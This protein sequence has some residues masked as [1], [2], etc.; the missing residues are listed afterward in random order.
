MNFKTFLLSMLVFATAVARTA[1]D[2]VLR[3]QALPYVNEAGRDQQ[4]GNSKQEC[5]ACRHSEISL[6][7]TAKELFRNF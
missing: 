1:D 2:V 5:S 3:P 4:G 6:G 7:I